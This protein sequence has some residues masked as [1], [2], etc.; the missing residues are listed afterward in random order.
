MAE[1]ESNCDKQQHVKEMLLQSGKQ[2]SLDAMV[3]KTEDRIKHL[4][5]NL[6]DAELD[7]EG[8]LLLCDLFDAELKNEGLLCSN[9]L[10]KRTTNDKP[11]P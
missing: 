4:R 3:E 7:N 10:P 2:A 5:C 8:L 1:N 11:R 6:F 9:L